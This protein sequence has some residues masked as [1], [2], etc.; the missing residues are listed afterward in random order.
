MIRIEVT[1]SHIKNGKPG[2]PT[3]CPV[4]LALDNAGYIRPV[5]FATNFVAGPTDKRTRYRS[6]QPTLRW[7]Q[8]FDNEE[9]FM[10]MPFEA[11]FTEVQID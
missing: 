9:G 3:S 2:S 10:A 8:G 7:I 1:Q 4:A 6:T 11:E 5:V